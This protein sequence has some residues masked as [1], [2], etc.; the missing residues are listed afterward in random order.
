MVVS[1]DNGESLL[2]IGGRCFGEEAKT[3]EIDA[4]NWDV[5]LRAKTG[6]VQNRAIS[7]ERNEEVA[8]FNERVDVFA[9][10]AFPCAMVLF[11][12]PMLDFAG[13]GFGRGYFGMVQNS[14]HATFA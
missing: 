5:V 10:T 14:D 6:G 2:P 11:N 3:A 13:E 4:E 12:Q 1:E 7:S 9:D 8:L